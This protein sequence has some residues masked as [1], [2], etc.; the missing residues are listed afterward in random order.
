MCCMESN[1]NINGV[2][3]KKIIVY[4][5]FEIFILPETRNINRDSPP[6]LQVSLDETTK[7]SQVEGLWGQPQVDQHKIGFVS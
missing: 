3:R 4:C 2:K 5:G 6:R 7:S 1:K